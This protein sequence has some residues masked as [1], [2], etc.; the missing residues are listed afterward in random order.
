MTLCLQENPL[1]PNLS[2]KKSGEH[3]EKPCHGHLHLIGRSG[4]V[5]RQGSLSCPR[6]LRDG[7]TEKA[8]RGHCSPHPWPGGRTVANP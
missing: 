6:Q 2:D 3:M 4:A 8:Q 1:V 7:D 5:L